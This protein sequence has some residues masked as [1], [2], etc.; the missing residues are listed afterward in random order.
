[1]AFRLGRHLAALAVKMLLFIR[2]AALRSS[3]AP[4]PGADRGV[5]D[6]FSGQSTFP[7]SAVYRFFFRSPSLVARRFD[8]NVSVLLGDIDSCRA[9]L[10]FFYVGLQEPKNVTIE[11]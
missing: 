5:N 6:A 9:R 7:S 8:L 2:T 1:M 10:S 11:K 3:Q 4:V